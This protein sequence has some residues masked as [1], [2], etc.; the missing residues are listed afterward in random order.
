MD[1][2]LIM[3][4]LSRE[5]TDTLKK[6]RKAKTAEEKLAY[7]QVVKNLSSSLGV[8]LGLITNVM[9]MG[10]DDDDMFDA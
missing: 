7:S 2:E 4:E 3:D 6:M 8:F 5:L 10:F 1:P 9:D